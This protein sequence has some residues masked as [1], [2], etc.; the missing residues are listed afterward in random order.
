GF[1][2]RKLAEAVGPSGA[3]VGVDVSEPLLAVARGLP[4]LEGVAPLTYHRGSAYALDLPDA[5]VDFI[6]SRLLFQHLEDPP[7]VL[8]E[9][10][11]VLRAGGAMCVVDSDDGILGL[12]P[13]PPGY[14]EFTRRAAEEQKAR[15]GDRDVGRK[16]GWYYKRAGF[17]DV[18][19]E[20]RVVTSDT[21]TMK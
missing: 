13:E 16:V 10:F 6:Y 14:A 1:L 3:V 4:P 8:R 2:A 9:C 11:R 5:S 15:G 20:V 18:R 12:F 7:R 19:V 21:M 17:T